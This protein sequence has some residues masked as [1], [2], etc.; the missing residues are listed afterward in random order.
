MATRPK[1]SSCVLGVFVGYYRT[2]ED[3]THSKGKMVVKIRCGRWDCPYCRERKAKRLFR[4]A[5]NG[6]IASE[7]QRS[8]FRSYNIKL[9]TLTYGGK[10]KRARSTPA[11]AAI[12]MQVAWAKLRKELRHLFGGFQFLKVFETHVDGWPHLHVVLCGE[13]IVPVKVLAEITRLW[14]Y[15]Y[16]FGFVKLNW[17]SEPKKA[18]RYVLKYM[19]KCPVQFSKVRLFSASQ[20][21]LMNP[22]KKHGREWDEKRLLWRDSGQTYRECEGLLARMGQEDVMIEAEVFPVKDC[23]F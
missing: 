21:A 17:C 2:C 18:L 14:R 5:M 8:G 4:R 12:E 11:E 1:R 6:E 15:R 3:G 23:P 20:G 16:G 22:A 7:A 19:F 10:G 13:S 9:L